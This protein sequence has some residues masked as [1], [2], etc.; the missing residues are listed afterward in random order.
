LAERALL[1]TKLLEA[2]L[3]KRRIDAHASRF[4]RPRGAF[5]P[6]SPEAAP[7]QPFE[8]RQLFRLF[9]RQT[10]QQHSVHQTENSRVGADPERQRQDRNDSQ[11]LVF[12]KHSRAIAQVLPKSGHKSS[13]FVVQANIKNARQA[14][15][16]LPPLISCGDSLWSS[17][18]NN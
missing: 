14:A 9:D 18:L 16:S 7:G 5:V 17:Q 10:F 6:E 8:L 15:P 3:Q 12:D 2:L 13:S 1:L 11:A 4:V